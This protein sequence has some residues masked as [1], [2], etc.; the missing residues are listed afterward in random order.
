MLSN[1]DRRTLHDSENT[2]SRKKK[3]VKKRVRNKAQWQQKA[4]YLLACLN[5]EE[6]YET[7]LINYDRVSDYFNTR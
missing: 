5:E 4:R 2:E 1:Q 7:G 3:R 6:D